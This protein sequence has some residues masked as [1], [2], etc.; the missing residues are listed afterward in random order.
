MEL[1][2]TNGGKMRSKF[3]LPNFNGV[4]MV[5]VPI[6]YNG[7]LSKIMEEDHRVSELIDHD[8]NC[9]GTARATPG[10]LKT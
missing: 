9:C 10:L 6:Y 5:S 1:E 2:C 4:G 7:N 8:P 3:Q